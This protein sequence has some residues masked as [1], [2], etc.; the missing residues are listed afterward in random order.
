M[1]LGLGKL[2]NMLA[3]VPNFDYSRWRKDDPTMAPKIVER[4][5]ENLLFATAAVERDTE[6]D[7]AGDE[8][9]HAVDQQ[10][11]GRQRP[12]GRRSGAHHHQRVRRRDLLLRRRPAGPQE[13]RDGR[14]RASWTPKLEGSRSQFVRSR[15][16]SLRLVPFT[17]HM[18]NLPKIRDALRAWAM[19][20]GYETTERPFESWKNGVDPGF[21]EEGEYDVFWALK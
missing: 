8:D 17:G 9:Q 19:T 6:Q 15:A 1:K 7:P 20:R 12:G 3:A 21:T 16:R 11:D 13:G 4:P 10:G 14:R 5:A 18:A 2:T